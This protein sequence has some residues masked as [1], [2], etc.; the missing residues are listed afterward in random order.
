MKHLE[1][2]SQCSNPSSTLPVHGA[3]CIAHHNDEDHR[4]PPL[5]D[6]VGAISCDS[7]G[8]MAAGVS[9]YA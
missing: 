7:E 9:R 2:E 3:G 6:T 5:Q 4:A 8:R 1:R